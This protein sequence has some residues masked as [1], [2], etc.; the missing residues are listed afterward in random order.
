[1]NDDELE[2]LLDNDELSEED[3]ILILRRRKRMR[4]KGL[5]RRNEGGA[6]ASTGGM[7]NGL[8][9]PSSA[10]ATPSAPR[11]QERVDWE[12]SE[13][14]IPGGA[15]T[16]GGT[17]AGGIFGEGAIPFDNYDP[18]SM[19]R[20]APAIQAQVS[21]RTL[22]VLERLEAQVSARDEEN[23]RLKEGDNETPPRRRL[24]SGQKW[25]K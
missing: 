4:E 25:G 8:A 1:M 6:L 18:A 11:G 10:N 5:A 12:A 24:R 9:F 15:Y 3:L 20:A 23:R 17:T 7:V 2:E 14:N 16:P 22:E 13:S 19:G 21:L